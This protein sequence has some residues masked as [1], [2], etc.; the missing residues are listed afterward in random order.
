VQ[1]A[2]VRLAPRTVEGSERWRPEQTHP[3]PPR[4]P[5]SRSRPSFR[6]RFKCA[7]RIS[8]R[9]FPSSSRCTIAAWAICRSCEAP[10]IHV[11][12]RGEGRS[13]RACRL[14]WAGNRARARDN[15]EGSGTKTLEAGNLRGRRRQCLCF[16]EP[17][18]CL[19]RAYLLA[20]NLARVYE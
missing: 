16:G 18:D 14:R 19:R 13:C 3:G 4:G 17:G 2:V 5:R 12:C 7:N 9:R 20:R 10:Q 11:R 1:G 15:A 8:A 6:M